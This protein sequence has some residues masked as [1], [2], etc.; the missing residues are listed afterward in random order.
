M[1]VAYGKVFLVGAGPGDPGLITVRGRACLERADV[2][3]YDNLA[4]DALLEYAPNAERIFAGKSTDHHTLLQDEINELL[5]EQAR[6]VARVVRLKGGDPFV[7]GRGGEEALFLAEHGIPF[8]IV[9]GVTSGIGALA[10]AGIP[11]TH[12]GL[13]GSVTLIT[14]HEDTQR[15]K[16]AVDLAQLAVQGTLVF[17]MG[18][19]SLSHIAAELIRLGRAP[20][21]PAAAIEWGTFPRQRT[22]H[23]RLDTIHELCERERVSPPALFVVGA[24]TA[25][26]E[27]LS[28]F[29]NRPLYGK[30]IAVTRARG[31]ASELV[32]ALRELGAD[33]FEFP[34]IE[35]ERVEA[36][37]DFGPIG[38]YH[39]VILTSVNGVDMLF[40][41]LE[42]LGLD[43]RGLAGVKLCVIGSAT[44]E[45]VQKR[46]LRCDLMPDKYVAE[47]LLEALV[48]REGALEGKRFLLPRADIARSFLP[49]ELRARGAEVTELIA[50][51][52]V[53]PQS[54]EQLADALVAYAP[55]FVTFTSSSTARNFCEILGPAR[56]AALQ[57]KAA[58][59]SIG[60]ITTQTA[61]D[62]GLAVRAEAQEH[63]I[64][65][66][67]QAIVRALSA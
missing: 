53:K 52:T 37:P 9:P 27:T 11:V 58:F 63:D 67:V 3:I 2:V 34:T 57:P 45:A 32:I 28:W 59:A 48:E 31:Q 19:K 47:S 7:F 30:R 33:V 14:G 65:G 46:F 44:R 41:R 54:S 26:S 42:T 36:P 10:Y 43:A 49:K 12:R 1:S 18:V 29:E 24:V 51:R 50:Y 38:A 60:P 56:L 66:L 15:H 5:L 4:N 25:L 35:I 61:Q 62:L 21:T 22:I 55:D 20:E 40:E 17:Y 8:E 23:G 39:W 6:K 13:A 16:P 64:P